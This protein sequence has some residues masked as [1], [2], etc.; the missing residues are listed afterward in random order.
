MEKTNV[1]F[2]QTN[3][4]NSNTGVA[5][6]DSSIVYFKEV[7][8]VTSSNTCIAMYSKKQEFG[9]SSLEIENYLCD[10]VNENFIQLG[11]DINIGS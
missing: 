7:L 5:I 11:N 9:P 1:V 6:K 10:S 4:K 8:E 2:G 3:I